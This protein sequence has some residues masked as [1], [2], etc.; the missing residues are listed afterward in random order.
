M[1]VAALQRLVEACISGTAEDVRNAGKVC[2][3]YLCPPFL[4]RTN[5][6]R[7]SLVQGFSG[8]EG[9][10]A[11]D[12]RDGKGRSALVRSTTSRVSNQLP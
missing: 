4:Y 9:A 1:E 2:G 7:W 10:A 12:V 5:A 6:R 3:Q 11:K 8:G